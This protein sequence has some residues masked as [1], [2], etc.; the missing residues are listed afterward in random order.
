MNVN[1]S[2]QASTELR[3]ASKTLGFE[4][5]VLVERAVSFYLDA[6]KNQLSLKKEFREWDKLSD[7]ALA[8]FEKTL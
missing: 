4:E 6:I 8:S 1:L 2:K 3:S 5:G 7:E